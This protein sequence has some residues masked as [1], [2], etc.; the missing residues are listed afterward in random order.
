MTFSDL[1]EEEKQLLEQQYQEQVPEKAVSTDIFRY[2]CPDCGTLLV[3]TTIVVYEVCPHLDPAYFHEV[4]E[5]D[6]EIY[7]VKLLKGMRRDSK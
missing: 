4:T 3:K 2:E 7:I 6:L 1:T 5:A